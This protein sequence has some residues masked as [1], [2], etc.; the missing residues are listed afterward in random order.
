MR[1]LRHPFCTISQGYTVINRQIDCHD[2]ER[3]FP[4]LYTNLCACSSVPL[5]LYFAIC[6]AY[7]AEAASGVSYGLDAY[8]TQLMRG[9]ATLPFALKSAHPNTIQETP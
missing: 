2:R 3:S 9:C 8:Q 5:H 6:S 4:Y 7:A 1:F